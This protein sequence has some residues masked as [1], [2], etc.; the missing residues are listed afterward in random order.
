[1]AGTDKKLRQL[2]Q[3]LCGEKGG[4]C[5]CWV[6]ST[7]EADAAVALAKELG[8][9]NPCRVVLCLDSPDR[10]YARQSSPT[11]RR[12]PLTPEMI[13]RATSLLHNLYG[14]DTEAMV[15]PGEPLAEIRRYVRTHNI[16]LV[17]MGEQALTLES[18]YDARL[19]DDPPCPVL[20]FVDPTRSN[21]VGTGGTDGKVEVQSLS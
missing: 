9:P 12:G 20:L 14:P 7:K 8:R 18:E 3:V 16:S 15:L 5:V 6:A 4:Q 11:R 17:V 19:I 10:L 1:M 13:G 2:W 21:Q